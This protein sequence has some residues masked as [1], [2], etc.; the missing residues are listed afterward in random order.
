M[1]PLTSSA[2]HRFK[3]VGI[4]FLLLVY[5]CWPKTCFHDEEGKRRNKIRD[6]SAI[7]VLIPDC[8][9]HKPLLSSRHVHSAILWEPWVFCNIFDAWD[10][11]L[12]K[13]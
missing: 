8:V 11:I 6:S 5:V 13:G 2:M 12:L 9:V 3:S 1:T 4:S 10:P 7:L